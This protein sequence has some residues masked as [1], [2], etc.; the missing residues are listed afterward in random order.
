LFVVRVAP[1]MTKSITSAT[2]AIIGEIIG[3]YVACRSK[4]QKFTLQFSRLRA[5]GLYGLLITGK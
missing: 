4:K 1:I 5:F 3:S 2:I